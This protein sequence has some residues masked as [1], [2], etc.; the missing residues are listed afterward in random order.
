M[1]SPTLTARSRALWESL[2]GGG[3]PFGPV[4]RVAESPDSQLCPP[5]WVGIVVIAD[6]VTVTAPTPDIA[7]VAQEALGTLPVA[8]LTDPAVLS[9]RLTL[10][11]VLG[12]A[13]LAYLDPAEF[14]PRHAAA[15]V[16]QFPPHD[17]E[18][19]QLVAASSAQDVQESGINQITSPAFTI[20]EHGTII[21]AAGYCDWP[22]QVAHMSVLTTATARGRGLASTVASAAL[23]HAIA[24]GKLPQWRARPQPSRSVARALGFRELGSQLSIRIAHP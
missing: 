23:T 16:E 21:S 8:S 10:L 7:H 6:A 1:Y 3:T 19:R 18:L 22:L 20:R 24:H 4:L 15:A 17:D 13:G 14:R 5:G 11:D 12:P 2:A 9:T